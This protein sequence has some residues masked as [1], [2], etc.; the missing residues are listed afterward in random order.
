MNVFINKEVKKLFMVLA[1][2]FLSF[3]ILGQFAVKHAAECYKQ[4]MVLHDYGIA[5]YLA[6]NGLDELHIIRSITSEKTNDDFAS[7]QELLQRAGYQS[8]VKNSLLPAVERFYQKYAL[9]LL[10]LSV[11]FSATVCIIFLFFILRQYNKIEKAD[12]DLRNFLAGNTGARL[13]DHIEGSLSKLFGSV[14]AMATSQ[15]AHIEKEKQSR[16][17]LKKTISDISHQLKTPLAA[18]RMYN[19]IIQNEKSGND[20]VDNFTWKSERELVRMETLIKN[21]LKL[22]RLDAGT[23]VLE[24]S[25]HRLKGFLD[26][27]I[28]GF[29][30]RAAMEGKSITLECDEQIVLDYDEEW[31]LEAVSNIIKNSLDHTEPGGR[32]GVLCGETPAVTEI[33][34]KD[35]GKGIHPE[36]FHNIFKRFYRSRFSKDKQGIGI[37]LTLARTIVEKHGGT[38]TVESEPG[39]GTAFHLVFPKLTVM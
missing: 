8:S 19:E 4:D 16:E 35:N 26:D 30:T 27:A 11:A 29:H 14:N 24:K 12:S 10:A 9:V 17:F 38:I 15:A 6:R 5:G 22:T 21:L 28:R 33:T 20:V 1:A 7:G 31:L 2:V 32:I 13:D 18:L 25:T 37:G 23:I 3:I 39:K 34:I 36:D